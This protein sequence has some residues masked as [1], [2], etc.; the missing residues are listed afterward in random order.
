MRAGELLLA[1]AGSM[2][3]LMAQAQQDWNRLPGGDVINS[4]EYLG[5]RLGSSVP[6]VLKTVPALPIDFYT[7][8][9]FRARINP[10]VQYPLLNTFP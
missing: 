9:I 1:L 2:A 10:R 4:T 3:M 8:D 5:A 7:T 6:L